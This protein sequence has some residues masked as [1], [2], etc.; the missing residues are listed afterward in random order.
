[1]AIV[2]G[3]DAGTSTT[4]CTVLSVEDSKVRFLGCGEAPGAGW[5]K[6]RVADQDRLTASIISAVGEASHQAQVQLESVVVGVGGPPV[7][8]YNHHWPYQFGRPREIDA[9]DLQF[10]VEKAA[11][12]NM[13]SDRM[14]LHVCPQD[15]TVDGRARH[16]F[17]RGATCMRL[18]ANVHL[19]TT[20]TL[21]TQSI[22]SAVHHAH[23]AVDETVFEPLAAGYAAV[24]QEDRSRGV[25]IIDIG[26]HSTDL[27]VYDGDALV[28][29]RSL[30]ICGD[31][32]TKDVAWG[33]T[34]SYED[35]E[36]L[37]CEYG[38]A[39]LGLTSDNSL[40]VV[41][42]LEGRAPVEAP[43]RR[44]TEILE[45][46]AEELF[47]YIEAELR[48]CGMEQGLIEGVV[49]TGGGSLLTGMCDMAERVL[50][51]PARKGLTVGVKDFPEDCDNPRW[52]AAAGLAMY[53]ARLR[54]RNKR[55]RKAPGLLGL[56]MR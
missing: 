33:F 51:C 8:G 12:V 49:L 4:R 14:I 34:V 28:H 35:A 25:T 3:L 21:E 42:S 17:P 31:H 22:V 20:S 10:A 32:F 46:R 1:M 40:I 30:P 45:A 26:A 29:S 52:T 48:Y 56:V 39:L 50:N 13:E 7:Y 2:A 41:P 43:R 23:L 6:G 54:H 53:A 18:E 11:D 15:F 16:H 44:L 37:K 19:V 47:L 36:A 38:C 5:F 9:S 27:V 24:L 55:R